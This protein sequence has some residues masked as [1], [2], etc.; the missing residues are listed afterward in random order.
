MASSQNK[1][2]ARL[3]FIEKWHYSEFERSEKLKSSLSYIIPMFFAEFSLAFLYLDRLI[4]KIWPTMGVPEKYFIEVISIVWIISVFTAL[5]F[6]FKILWGAD[7]RR[8]GKPA[9]WEKYLKNKNSD[10]VVTEIEALYFE[11]TETN[12]S[13]NNRMSEIRYSC[14]LWLSISA[15]PTIIALFFYFVVFFSNLA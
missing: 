14:L 12:Y 1:D 11:C 4:P 15:I 7:Y 9:L 10:D 5:W 3:D 13:K 8:H 2:N 6:L